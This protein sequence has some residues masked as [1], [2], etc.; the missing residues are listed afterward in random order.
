MEPVYNSNVQL[1]PQGHEMKW[2]QT[3][4]SS[5]C[6]LCKTKTYNYSRWECLT[7]KEKYCVGCKK[8]QAFNNRCPI[9]HELIERE[10]HANRC[11]SCRQSINGKGFRDKDCDFDLCSKCMNYMVKED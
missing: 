10:L 5:P 1:C 4:L 3:Y 8:P 7:C 11:D 2:T 6:P 9:N